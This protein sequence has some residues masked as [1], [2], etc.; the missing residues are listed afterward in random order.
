MLRLLGQ[1]ASEAIQKDDEEDSEV[2][3]DEGGSA[4]DDN[5]ENADASGSEDEEQQQEA[6]G[7]EEEDDEEPAGKK[8]QKQPTA[9]AA[10][11]DDE[12]DESDDAMDDDAMMRLDAQLG[13]AVRSMLAGRGGSAKE[14]AASLLGLQLRVAAL[15]EEWFKK[16][17]VA[18]AQRCTVM[19]GWRLVACMRHR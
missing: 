8:Q 1:R 6:S 13:A 7:S 12:N 2:E 10:A 15:L 16:V 18:A 14:R 3:M 9:A 17:R 11:S 4:S 19:S 5:P